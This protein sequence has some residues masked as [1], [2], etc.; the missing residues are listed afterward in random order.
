[1]SHIKNM[2]FPKGIINNTSLIEVER[3]IHYIE[4]LY[5]STNLHEHIEGITQK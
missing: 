1:M 3:Q 5:L 2:S 4:T